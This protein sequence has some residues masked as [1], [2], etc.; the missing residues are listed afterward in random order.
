MLGLSFKLT[1]AQVS[2]IILLKHRKETITY[3]DIHGKTYAGLTLPIELAEY[4]HTLSTMNALQRKG[5][6]V[7]AEHKSYCLT[8]EGEA[9]A[10]L[11][12]K[13]AKEIVTIVESSRAEVQKEVFSDG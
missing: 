13:S 5:L 7:W 2:A 4:T 1:P 3:T 10:S 8:D 6:V 12:Y 9:I 11:I